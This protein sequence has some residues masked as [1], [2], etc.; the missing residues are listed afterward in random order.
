LQIQE[1]GYR[2]RLHDR[3]EGQQQEAVLNLYAGVDSFVAKY[4]EEF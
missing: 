1:A 4:D 3:L 2:K